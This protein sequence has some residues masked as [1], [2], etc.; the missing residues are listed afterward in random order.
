VYFW[1]TSPPRE[2][3]VELRSWV[4]AEQS[5]LDKPL[6]DAVERWLREEWPWSEVEYA[7]R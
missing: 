4:T 5:A 3:A 2:G 7:S 1:P 6:H